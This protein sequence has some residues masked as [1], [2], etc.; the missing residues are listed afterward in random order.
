MKAK[1]IVGIFCLVALLGVVVTGITLMAGPE[2]GY[3][4]EPIGG[5]SS[6]GGPVNGYPDEPIGSLA[7]GGG[8]ENGYPDEPIGSFRV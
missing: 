7:A 8:P 5:F 2:N 6:G 1:K 4:D 3:P